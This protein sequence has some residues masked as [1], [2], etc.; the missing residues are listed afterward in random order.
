MEFVQ[1][2]YDSNF[3]ETHDI[4][5]ATIVFSMEDSDCRK[6]IKCA[7]ASLVYIEND[8]CGKYLVEFEFK[9]PH[10]AKKGKYVGTFEITVD[11]L[12]LIAPIRNELSIHVI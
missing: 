9:A 11:G 12:V 8:G 1:T 10:T 3:W 6:K 5:S 2:G 7:P 4:E